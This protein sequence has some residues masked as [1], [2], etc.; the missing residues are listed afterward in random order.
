MLIKKRNIFVKNVST[1]SQINQ[2]QQMPTAASRTSCERQAK[3]PLAQSFPLP[4]GD[5]VVMLA[6]TSGASSSAASMVASDICLCTRL[7]DGRGGES[8]LTHLQS[9]R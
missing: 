4:T 6:A 7:C 9:Q 5:V 2:Y 1:W 8:H 3:N